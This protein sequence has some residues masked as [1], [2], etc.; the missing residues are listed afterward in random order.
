MLTAGAAAQSNRLSP[1]QRG[2][3]W[4][5][6]WRSCAVAATVS[7][8][9]AA[10]AGVATGVRATSEEGAAAA[11][12]PLAGLRRGGDSGT[13]PLELATLTSRRLLPGCGRAADDDA[14]AAAAAPPARRRWRLLAAAAAAAAAVAAFASAA[15]LAAA[16]EV[17]AT[18]RRAACAASAGPG[19]APSTSETTRMRP[20][21]R[22]SE[23][24]HEGNLDRKRRSTACRVTPSS[25]ISY[26]QG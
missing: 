12:W 6:A 22:A 25:S 10:A 19:R 11:A 3:T 4:P 21:K 24:G 1:L 26:L 8:T 9:S 23:I 2:L 7:V 15:A 14:A 16:A 20:C 18:L 5:S 13:C 17:A